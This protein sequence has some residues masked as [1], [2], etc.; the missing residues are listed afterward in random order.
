N[1]GVPGTIAEF[2]GIL[3]AM[4]LAALTGPTTI[5]L[6]TDQVGPFRSAMLVGATTGAASVYFF[7]DGGPTTDGSGLSMNTLVARYHN[8][9]GLP[10]GMFIDVKQHPYLPP[11]TV[12]FDVERLQET[13]ANSRMGETRGVFVR[14]DTY[15][16]EF[17]QTSRKYPFGVFSEEVL[18][19]KTPNLIAFLT[20]LGPFGQ[21]N[22]F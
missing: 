8:V 15:G 11:G 18:A 4:Q 20:G 17:A 9:F 7:P 14:R 3:F 6:S 2:D 16:I 5:Y 1:N 21:A 13:Y 12:L 19:V 10:G 22:V